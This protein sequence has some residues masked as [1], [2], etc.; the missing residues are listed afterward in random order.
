MAIEVHELEH[1]AQVFGWYLYVV[2]ELKWDSC[3]EVPM[4]FPFANNVSAW[5]PSEFVYYM[6]ILLLLVQV[7]CLLYFFYLIGCKNG[8]LV[9]TCVHDII[10]NIRVLWT[11]GS[12]DYSC[13]FCEKML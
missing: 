11:A 12:H 13:S 6:C 3:A 10:Y 7:F 2:G 4:Q 9:H 8:F 5:R 1:D